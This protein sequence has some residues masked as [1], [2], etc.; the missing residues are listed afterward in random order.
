METEF[1]SG[2]PSGKGSASWP[3][4]SN[5]CQMGVLPALR[6]ERASRTCPTSS[7]Y[8]PLDSLAQEPYSLCLLGWT[9]PCKE[10]LTSLGLWPNKLQSWKTGGSPEKSNITGTL[11]LISTRPTAKL[12]SWRTPYCYSRGSRHTAITDLTRHMSQTT[13]PTLKCSLTIAKGSVNNMGGVLTCSLIAQPR[14][15]KCVDMLS[16]GGV[17]SLASRTMRARPLSVAWSK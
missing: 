1:K 17:M 10:T 4:S 5:S 9:E 15:T 3:S 7:S 12:K 6:I 2:S 13:S 11:T 14:L 16:R 8:T